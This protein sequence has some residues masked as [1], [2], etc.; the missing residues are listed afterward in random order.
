LRTALA[1][2]ETLDGSL[3]KVVRSPRGFDAHFLG[4]TKD[5]AE[6]ACRRLNSR[7]VTCE[8]LGPAS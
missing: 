3:R 2:M 8:T 4:M 5:G 1:E 6:L 7:N